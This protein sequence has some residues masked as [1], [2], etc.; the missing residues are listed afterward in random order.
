MYLFTS[1]LSDSSC[2][3]LRARRP[4]KEIQFPAEAEY[5]P[6]LQTSEPPLATIQTPTP[7]VAMGTS[8]S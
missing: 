8:L 5:F 6:L 2:L 1:V 7:W 3:T 4:R